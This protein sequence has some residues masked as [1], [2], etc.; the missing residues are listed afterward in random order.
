MVKSLQ[1]Y[2]P[3]KDWYLKKG[4]VIKLGRVVFRVKELQIEGRENGSEADEVFQDRFVDIQSFK[5]F[6]AYFLVRF[7]IKK[8]A[9][10][11]VRHASSAI[12]KN[13]L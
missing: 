9:P 8:I 13:T 6:P 11:Q 2:N 4:D 3:K 1:N 10:K 12:R 7:T 5:S